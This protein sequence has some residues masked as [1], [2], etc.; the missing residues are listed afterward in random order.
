MQIEETLTQVVQDVVQLRQG[1]ADTDVGEGD[2]WFKNLLCRILA[3]GGHLK[4]GHTW[5][6]QNRPTEVSQD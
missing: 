1:I 6:L 3:L 4:T 2:V 5:P